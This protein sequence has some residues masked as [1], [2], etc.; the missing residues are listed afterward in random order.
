MLIGLHVVFLLVKDQRCVGSGG[1]LDVMDGRQNLILNLDQLFGLFQHCLILRHYQ[2]HGIAQIMGQAADR[3]EGVL[4][5]LQMADFVFAGD[6]FCRQNGDDAG[7]LFGSRCVDGQH[8]GAGV[9][10]AHGGAVA[11]AVYIEI[12]GELAVAQDFFL[13]V[14]PV[15]AGAQLPVGGRGQRNLALPQD[16]AGQTDGGDDLHIAGAAAVV[17]ADGKA[18]LLIRG[19]RALVQQGLA[20]QNHARDAEAA[21][22]GTGFTESKGE[23]CLFKIGQTLHR[24]HPLAVQTVG[25]GNTGAAGFAVDQHRAGTAGTLAA[26]VLG[27]GDMQFVA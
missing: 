14:Q 20:A 25:V 5:V 26:A 19:I 18:D 15:D 10:A 21:L 12:V 17:I 1:L 9:F 8:P 13:Y 3:D 4:V 6:V 23:R 2:R 11:H 7:Q 16:L 24:Q 27:G 22:Y